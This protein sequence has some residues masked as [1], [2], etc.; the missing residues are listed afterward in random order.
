MRH[1]PNSSVFLFCLL[2]ILGCTDDAANERREFQKLEAAIGMV[3]NATREDRGI[4]L[5]QLESVAVRFERMAKLKAIC[6]SS[7]RA[8]EKASGLLDRARR[9]TAAAEEVVAAA[10]RKKAE[11]GTL[12]PEEEANM[13]KA[14]KLA[15]ESLKDVTRELSAAES[16]VASCQEKRNHYRFELTAAP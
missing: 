11:F 2:I 14:G 16:L 8:F 12:T 15:A 3:A 9:N 1:F 4:R 10:D 6:V 5:E 7:Y 13:L